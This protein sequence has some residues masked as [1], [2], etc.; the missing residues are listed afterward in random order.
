MMKRTAVIALSIF[1]A[2]IAAAQATPITKTTFAATISWV[3]PSVCTTAAPCIFPVGRAT[4]AAG[5]SSCPLTAS[6]YSIVG[7]TAAQASSYQDATISPATSYC[8]EVQTSQAGAV[9]D[10]SVPVLLAVPSVPIAPGTPT[11]STT[12]IT[13][14]VTNLP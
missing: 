6:S 7:T 9:S 2:V 3:D 4:L 12:V 10:P 8:Y 14:T 5:I 11:A 13:V 1:A